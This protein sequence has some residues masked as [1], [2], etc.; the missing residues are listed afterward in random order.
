MPTYIGLLNFTEQGVKN[1]K[2]SPKRAKAFMAQ[3][4]KLDAKVKAFFGPWAAMIWWSWWMPQA[5]RLQAASCWGWAPWAMYGLKR[6]EPLTLKSLKT[7]Y[8]DSKR[9]PYRCP[10][11]A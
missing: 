9:V 1:V 11:L 2:E 4:E 10:G 8:R 3:A 7:L 5:T 6:S